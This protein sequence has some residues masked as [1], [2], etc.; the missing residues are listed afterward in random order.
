MLYKK[1]GCQVVYS[2][3]LFYLNLDNIVLCFIKLIKIVEQGTLGL[4]SFVAAVSE[5]I[6][7]SPAGSFNRALYVIFT[8]HLHNYSEIFKLPWVK[9]RRQRPS[10]PLP[11]STTLCS[12]RASSNR[13]TS[14]P[15]RDP[16][17]PS[18]SI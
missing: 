7:F 1:L 15:C 17:A 6:S 16:A 9:R 14:S 10:Q 4:R 8:A 13:A 2:L 18:L 11:T 12:R 5:A 3:Q